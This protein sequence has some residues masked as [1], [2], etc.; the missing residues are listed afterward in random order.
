M[1]ICACV[2]A[3]CMQACVFVNMRICVYVYA[4]VHVHVQV[5]ECTHACIFSWVK[6]CM[7]WSLYLCSSLG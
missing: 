3:G 1:C 2:F 6:Q 7:S 5:C 4:Y